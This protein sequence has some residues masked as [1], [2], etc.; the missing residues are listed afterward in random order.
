MLPEELRFRA[1]LFSQLREFFDNQGFIETSTPI[2]LPVILPEA[3]IKPIK[4]GEYFLQTSPEMC[5]KM[6]LASG[7]DKIYQLCSCFRSEERGRLHQE[8]FTMLE[9]YRRN[10]DYFRLMGDCEEL[11][12]HLVERLYDH[13]TEK[14]LCC[15]KGL[16]SDA[17]YSLS[18][19][20]Q[21]ISVKEAFDRW[22]DKHVEQA[23]D[24][25]SFDEI[26]VSSIEP[27]LGNE[28]PAFLYDYP[29]AYASLARKK[30]GDKRYGERFELYIKG[31]EIANG[32]SELTDSHEQRRRF[33]QE[34]MHI[35]AE[36]EQEMKMPEVFLGKL[37]TIGEA[38]GIALGVD[39]LLMVLLGRSS[40]EEVVPFT[41]DDFFP[42]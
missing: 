27:E 33:E 38:A 35:A 18:R 40:M 28:K 22:G 5:M 41:V 10:A 16:L 29:A 4:T 2:R 30:P 20:W 6:L 42:S 1:A 7:C 32:F 37:D 11:L 31:I 19:P 21:K 26:L 9:W 13:A 39:R 8:E 23:V 25:G 12:H 34:L 3:N 17:S 15:D 36:C 14:S 24:D